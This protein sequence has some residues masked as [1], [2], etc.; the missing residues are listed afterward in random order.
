VVTT[1]RDR[2]KTAPS[3]CCTVAGYFNR[4]RMVTVYAPES[5]VT[6]SKRPDTIGKANHPVPHKIKG[7]P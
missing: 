6:N 5:T 3:P 1:V 4:P 7:K 2:P